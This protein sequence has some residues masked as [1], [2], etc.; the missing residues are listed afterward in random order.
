MIYSFAAYAEHH[1][2]HHG[3]VVGVEDVVGE[4]PRERHV[5]GKLQPLA[6]R[7][8]QVELAEPELRQV[9]AVTHAFCEQ[10]LN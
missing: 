5:D 2:L 4:D 10:S 3:G 7:Q 9:A 6:L 1:S 8:L